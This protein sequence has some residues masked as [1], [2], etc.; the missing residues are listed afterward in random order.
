MSDGFV[1][2]QTDLH[3]AFDR[4]GIQDG[5]R[6]SAHITLGYWAR[7]RMQKVYVRP[8]LWIID[9][10]ELVEVQGHGDT[11]R[12]ES[13]DAWRPLL[14]TESPTFQPDLLA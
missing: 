4:H 13:L 1:K 8:V 12:Y 10:I 2:F 14:M 7:Q 3:S 5:L 9:T 6:H 11:Y